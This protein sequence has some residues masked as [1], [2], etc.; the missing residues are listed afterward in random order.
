MSQST[1]MM[2]DIKDILMGAVDIERWAPK[3]NISFPFL[4]HDEKEEIVNNIL[5]ELEDKGYKIIKKEIE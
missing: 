5:T 4:D 1:F 2:I 3:S